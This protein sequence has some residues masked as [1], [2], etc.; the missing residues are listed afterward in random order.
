[1]KVNAAAQPPAALLEIVPV[2]VMTDDGTTESVRA[3]R[4]NA[5]IKTALDNGG[6]SDIL[7]NIVMTAIHKGTVDEHGAKVPL[8]P[9]GSGRSNSR[10]GIAVIARAI[11]GAFPELND[12]QA[13][14]RA[15]E[16][17]KDLQVSGYVVVNPNARVPKYKPD[18]SPN[19]N[20]NNRKALE[21]RWD[22]VPWRKPDGVTE[23]AVDTQPSSTGSSD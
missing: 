13:R 15:D 7:R 3:I 9:S 23:T 12:A 11:R 16:V 1:M 17:L 8:S 22:L 6:V 21:C 18:G 20:N 5:Q 10:D 19:G 2:Q 4:F 14:K